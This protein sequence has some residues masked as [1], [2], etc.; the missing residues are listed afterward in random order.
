MESVAEGVET[1]E[2]AVM[3][4]ALNVRSLQGYLVAPPMPVELVASWLEGW[5]GGTADAGLRVAPQLSLQTQEVMRLLA[6]G[7]SVKQIA[8]ALGFT[9]GAVKVQIARAYTAMGTQAPAEE[10]TRVPTAS[11]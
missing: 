6:Q 9:V 2:V 3:L 1:E 11:H 5:I 8:R 4:E 10:R 7:R